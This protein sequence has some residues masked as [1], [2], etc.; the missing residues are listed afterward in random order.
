MADDF[1]RLLGD[2][3]I[4]VEI[5]AGPGNITRSLLMHSSIRHVVAVEKDIRFESAL[6][7]LQKLS[8]DRLHVVFDDAMLGHNWL[9]KAGISPDRD[10]HVAIVGNLP[11]NIGTPLLVGWIK[12]F[13]MG[14]NLFADYR[15]CSLCL[16]LQREVADVVCSAVSQ[17]SRKRLSAL[18]QCYMQP[19]LVQTIER[20]HFTPKPKVDVG[21]VRLVGLSELPRVP[22]EKLAG[23]ITQGFSGRNKKLSSNFKASP[24]KDQ[25]A[26]A[27]IA[28]DIDPARR[29]ATLES[30]EWIK[31]ARSLD[32]S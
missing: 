32:R 9:L 17:S 20:S 31:L 18:V 14:R 24:F 25:F 7:T 30:S 29:P 3:S 2:P 4:V 5:G 23:V 19:E 10:D 11:F 12:D 1:V 8:D 26:E 28:C 22:F 15:S 21:T 27:C 16:M 13:A 6:S